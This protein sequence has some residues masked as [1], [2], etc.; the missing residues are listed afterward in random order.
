MPSNSAC[1]NSQPPEGGWYSDDGA[2]IEVVAFQ[3]TAARR[4]LGDRNRAASQVQVFQLTAA[5][6]RLDLIKFATG[7]FVLFQLTAARRRLGEAG[8]RFRF[9][10]TVSTHSRPKAAG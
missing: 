10:S 2:P 1:F 6:R 9:R 4:R 7:F 3:L 8:R 5:R